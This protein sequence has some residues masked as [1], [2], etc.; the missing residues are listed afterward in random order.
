MIEGRQR[1]ARAIVTA[2]VALSVLGLGGGCEAKSSIEAAQTAI[3]AAQTAMPAVQTALPSIAT[4]LQA[5][6]PGVGIE[7]KPTP[8]GVSNDAVTEVT[9][10]GTDSRGTISQL[11][12]RSRQAA[13]SGAL[14]LAA[15]YYPNA[16]ISL[17]VVDGAGT[18]LVSGTKAPGQAPA[19]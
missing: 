10:L 15:Q 4:Q 8:E 3:V 17:R 14:L 13:V 19:I 6:L 9:I 2:L 5:L 11:D 12:P 18:T 7:V 1:A 16:T